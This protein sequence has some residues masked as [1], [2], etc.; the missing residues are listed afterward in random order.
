MTL[1]VSVVIPTHNSQSTIGRAL[2]SVFEQTKCPHEVIVVDDCST[3]DTCSIVRAMTSIAPCSIHLIVLDQNVGPS[4]TRNAGWNAATQEY[5]AFLDSDDTWHPQKLEV[6]HKWMTDHPEYQI[7]GHLTGTSEQSINLDCI[8]VQYFQLRH[9]LIRNRISTPTVMIRRE[10]S[11]RFDA[12]QRYSEDYDLW[13]RIVCKTSGIVRIEAPLTQLH[14][15]D[16]GESGLS[17]KLFEMYRGE[18]SAMSKLRSSGEIGAPSWTILMAW[19][20]VKF[21]LRIVRTRVQSI[22]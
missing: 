22:Q 16:F 12:A 11:E 4:Q 19:L 18:L 17:S 20:T 7:T 15:A 8:E 13:L 5:V 10:V 9:F 14:K 1:S 6:Q 21:L 2:N 3:D